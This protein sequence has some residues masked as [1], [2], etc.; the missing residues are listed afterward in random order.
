MDN[1]IEKETTETH[2]EPVGTGQLSEFSDTLG[3]AFVD[4]LMERQ[5]DL[6]ECRDSIIEACER[7]VRCYLREGMV[8]TCGNGGSASDSGHIVGELMKGFRKT[9]PLP[10]GI[11]STLERLDP[12][13]AGTLLPALQQPLPAIDLT[14]QNA[15]LTAFVNDQSPDA[16]FAQQVLAYSQPENVLIAMSTSGN[17]T[18]VVYA[19]FTAK[20]LGLTTIGLTGKG[21]GELANWC[22]VLIAVPETDTAGV[23]ELHLPIYHTLCTVVEAHFFES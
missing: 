23:Q 2:E 18:N 9:R 7:L 13:I 4:S 6:A 10:I 12:R 11:A 21:G 19:A 14:A 17:S 5:R 8:L 16:V 3:T 1:G 22:D 20:A 15:L